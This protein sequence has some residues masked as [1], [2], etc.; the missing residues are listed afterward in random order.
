MSIR[1]KNK[2]EMECTTIPTKIVQCI[3]ADGSINSIKY[4]L[5]KRYK[6]IQQ[7]QKQYLSSDIDDLLESAIN[8]HM[9]ETNLELIDKRRERQQPTK[10]STY[11]RGINKIRNSI[12]R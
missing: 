7:Q 9:E 1:T 11:R 10:R 3:N 12:R 8:A 5:F 2:N 4:I 6:R